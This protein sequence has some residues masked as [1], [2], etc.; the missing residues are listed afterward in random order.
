VG[1]EIGILGGMYM[2]LIKFVLE[3]IRILALLAIV[4]G[5]ANSIFTDWF[6]ISK[7]DTLIIF[8]NVVVLVLFTMWYRRKG[9]YSGWYT[10]A[11][12]EKK[13]S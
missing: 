7:S 4:G 13:P 5:I 3:L 10:K 2:I 11:K 8:L 9:Q 1:S 6:H 12:V